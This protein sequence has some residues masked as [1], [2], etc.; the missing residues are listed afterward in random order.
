MVI[1]SGI[2]KYRIVN[3]LFYECISL[4]LKV[5]AYHWDLSSKFKMYMH[6]VLI[7]ATCID[8]HICVCVMDIAFV[9]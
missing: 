5:K 3:E 6:F 2:I 8:T 4:V 7:V 1:W 9:L